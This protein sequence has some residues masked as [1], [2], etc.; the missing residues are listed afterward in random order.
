MDGPVDFANT[1]ADHNSFYVFGQ[2]LRDDLIPYIEANFQ[3]MQ[4][5]MKMVMT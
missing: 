4:T 1:S 3:P 2:E 5:I